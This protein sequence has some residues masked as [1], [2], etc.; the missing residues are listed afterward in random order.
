MIRAS[1]ASC[2]PLLREG[3]AGALL[4]HSAATPGSP[5]SMAT[6][7]R[8]RWPVSE[9][10]GEFGVRV[11]DAQ[12][13]PRGD[14]GR[15]RSGRA[16]DG[17]RPRGR[18]RRP[19]RAREGPSRLGASLGLPRRAS[20]LADQEPVVASQ[21]PVLAPRAS[22]RDRGR[23][24]R[25]RGLESAQPL[26]AAADRPQWAYAS[27]TRPPYVLA[28]PGKERARVFA[29]LEVAGPPRRLAPR[30]GFRTRFSPPLGTAP[31]LFPAGRDALPDT[32]QQCGN[33]SPSHGPGCPF[34]STRCGR[35][36]G[37]R[38]PRRCA[39]A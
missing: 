25:D 27:S 1:A 5:R 3:V 4:S 38:P 16:G 7:P 19:S 29:R 32:E 17:H 8:R 18:D 37:S 28:R 30:L 34:M 14:R 15:A 20:D 2:S 22:M 23:P 13:P 11:R 33:P 31:W 21:S 6:S 10:V 24:G 36:S 39:G 9:G 12:G 26:V 35:A